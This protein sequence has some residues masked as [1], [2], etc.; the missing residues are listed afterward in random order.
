MSDGSWIIWFSVH[1]SATDK[2][3]V[4][5]DT[6]EKDGEE[7]EE[8]GEEENTKSQKLK[9]YPRNPT[10]QSI[11]RTRRASGMD[12]I[13]NSKQEQPLQNIADEINKDEQ[14]IS[15]LKEKRSSRGRG[16]GGR[17]VVAVKRFRSSEKET[18][19]D[20]SVSKSGRGRGKVP[21]VKGDTT[22]RKLPRRPKK[23][24]SRE[25]EC[26]GEE[27]IGPLLKKCKLEKDN[28]KEED[29]HVTD[30]DKEG[31]KSSPY[32]GKGNRRRGK[33][34]R[35]EI[36][37]ED[38]GEE[39]EQ[40]KNEEEK[41]DKPMKKKRGRPKKKPM[42]LTTPTT[43]E[44]TDDMNTCMSSGSQQPVT[45]PV[46]DVQEIVELLEL[47]ENMGNEGDQNDNG[48][49]NN[50]DTPVIDTQ[51]MESPEREDDKEMKE[52][53]NTVTED[54]V[55]NI[56]ESKMESESKTNNT[57]ESQPQLAITSEDIT[58]EDKPQTVDNEITNND[59]QTNISHPSNTTVDDDSSN[60]KEKNNSQKENKEITTME[61]VDNNEEATNN[62]TTTT[63]AAVT[64][65]VESMPPTTVPLEP[66]YPFPG[67]RFPPIDD[68]GF[69][70]FPPMPHPFLSGYPPFSSP[71][72]PTFMIPTS[73]HFPQ[74][75]YPPECLPPELYGRFTEDYSRFALPPIPQGVTTPT[76]CTITSQVTNVHLSH[77]YHMMSFFFHCRELK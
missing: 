44:P 37:V 1:F 47:S 33:R 60:D 38:G 22:L 61:T 32:K 10:Y 20:E 76:S 39:Q 68:Q 8:L 19:V 42:E 34:G 12:S 57:S 65:V 56:G 6:T 21:L 50:N 53:D 14:N 9:G 51:T 70:P 40:K 45:E 43:D 18:V 26:D 30:S 46:K 4:S 27:E 63:S 41:E 36:K 35:F 74:S 71:P 3:D 24:K 55:D 72:Y 7:F 66:T 69:H 17:G 67:H 77:D 15:D 28:S 64:Q 73:P 52:N 58:S 23:Q 31:T 29:D 59:N 5:V 13:K 62:T 11:I 54:G 16:R 25:E 75:P 49:N 2:I 48:D